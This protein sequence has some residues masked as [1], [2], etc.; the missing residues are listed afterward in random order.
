MNVETKLLEGK[1]LLWAVCKALGQSPIIAA[2]GI[3]YRSDHGSWVYPNYTSD[4]EAGELMASEWISAE[5]PT[6]GQSTPMW[7]TV[8]ESKK[9]EKPYSPN[10][11]VVGWG[12]TLGVAVGRAIVLSYIGDKVDIPKELIPTPKLK[13]LEDAYVKAVSELRSKQ[14]GYQHAKELEKFLTIRDELRAHPEFS[15]VLPETFFA[16]GDPD[17]LKPA[18]EVARG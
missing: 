16:V 2:T 3:A 15:G 8:M 10:G 18:R 9:P 13:E 12:E 7:R 17:E 14:V 11:P 1:A 5:R 6:K 4:S